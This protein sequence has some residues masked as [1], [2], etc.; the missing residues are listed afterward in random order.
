MTFSPIDPE[1]PTYR[2]VQAGVLFIS[3]NNFYSPGKHEK[4]VFVFRRKTRE[5]WLEMI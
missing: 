3:M 1:G 2:T 5:H 4:P